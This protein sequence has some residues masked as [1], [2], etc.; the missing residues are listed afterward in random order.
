[1]QEGDEATLNCTATINGTKVSVYWI[2]DG[3]KLQMDEDR[4]FSKDNFPILDAACDYDGNYTCFTL[5]SNSR[6]AIL[7]K[8]VVKVT[9]TF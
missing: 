4:Y 3:E 5:D 7:K 9:G 2:K 6:I 8:F 1:M